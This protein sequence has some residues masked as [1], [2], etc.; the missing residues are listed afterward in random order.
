M[1]TSLKRFR[2]QRLKK[3]KGLEAQRLEGSNFLNLINSLAIQHPGLP[4]FQP[5]SYEL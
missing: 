1:V 5:T 2:V 4:A 3:L